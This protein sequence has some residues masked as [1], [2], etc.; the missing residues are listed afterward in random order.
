MGVVSVIAILFSLYVKSLLAGVSS[1]MKAINTKIDSIKKCIN[2]IQIETLTK[3]S[4]LS[5]RIATIESKLTK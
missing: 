5:E 1:D 4:E 2:D 3:I